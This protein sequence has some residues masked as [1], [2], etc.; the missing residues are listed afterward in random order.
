[1][2]RQD[3]YDLIDSERDY[4]ESTWPNSTA[5][6][7]PGEVLLIEDYL[8][9]FK[10]NYQKYDD[11]PNCSAPI[12]CLQD[13]RKIATLAVRA[14]ENVDEMYKDVLLRPKKNAVGQEI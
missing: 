2:K 8:R 5:L 3:V 7:T 12:P 6:P 4:Q 14:L 11:G 13:L 10:M 1:M 9:Q